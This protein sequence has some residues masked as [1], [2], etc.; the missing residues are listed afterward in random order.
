M[1]HPDAAAY[2]FRHMMLSRPGKVTDVAI[3]LAFR[4]FWSHGEASFRSKAI[5][6]SDRVVTSTI[7]SIG[8]SL[9]PYR[10]VVVPP[11]YAG[12]FHVREIPLSTLPQ[13]LTTDLEMS[14]YYEP[15]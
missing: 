4:D 6:R 11:N 1:E 14:K 8:V 3:N 10:Q 7:H 2:L 9:A 15:N 5:C 13:N 12:L